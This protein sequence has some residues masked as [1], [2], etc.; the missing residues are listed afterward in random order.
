MTD[1]SQDVT[2]ALLDAAAG[3]TGAAEDLWSL[4][5]DELRR[6]ARR[7]LQ[8]ERPDHTLTPTALV[9][10]AYVRL[11]DQTRVEW[12]DRSHFF[13]IA[14]RVCRRIL[15]D[16]ARRRVAAKRGGEAVRVTLD[17]GAAVTEARSEEVL[18]LN[19]ALDRLS[20]LS[21]RLGR[22]VEMRY[23]GGL[24]EEETAEALGVTTRTVRRDWVKAKGFLYDALYGGDRDPDPTATAP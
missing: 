8:R 14:S 19:E 16:H 6:I 22:V 5:Y 11:V 10:E 24:S 9:H 4:T 2:R 17:D 12:R 13:A 3:D 15:V 20:T 7:H 18:A 1:R 21:E 23:F